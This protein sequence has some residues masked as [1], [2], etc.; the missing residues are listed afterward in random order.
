[1]VTTIDPCPFC[2]SN[3]THVTK[4]RLTNYV[5]CQ[6]CNSCGPRH[7]Q[8]DMAIEEWN[9]LSQAQHKAQFLAKHSE[10]IQELLGQLHQLES[11]V[12]ELMQ[13]NLS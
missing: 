13:E 4:S 2:R 10:R 7:R 3:H 8:S 11:G 1:M 9:T 12:Q 6:H 5:V